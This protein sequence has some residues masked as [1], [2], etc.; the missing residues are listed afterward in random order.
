MILLI[1]SLPF[2][3]IIKAQTISKESFQ[4]VRPVAKLNYVP[5]TLNDFSKSSLG[6]TESDLITLPNGKKVTMKEYLKTVNYVE[7]N[8]SDLGYSKDRQ[9]N[10][11]VLSKFKSSAPDL[12]ELSTATKAPLTKT[13]LANR[14]TIASTP[15]LQPIL[16]S[17]IDQTKTI[18][19][20]N[21]D[22]LPNDTISRSEKFNIPKFKVAGYGVKIDADFT[23]NGIVDP[24][25]VL[26]RQKNQ[27]SLNKVITNT[28]NEYSMGFN[29][30]IAAELPQIGNYS[31]YEI[32]S[33][34]STKAN[35]SIKSKASLKVMDQLLIDENKTISSNN[36]SFV[37]NQVFNTQKKIGA[38][39]IFMYGLNFLSP[40]DFYLSSNAVGGDFDVTMTKTNVHGTIGPIITQSIFMESSVTELL[41]PGGEF[42]N[43]D[44]LDAGVG[45]ELRLVEGGLDFGGSIGLTAANGSLSLK[46]DVY[47]SIDVKLL[48]GRLYTYYSYPAFVCDAFGLLNPSCYVTKRVENNLFDTG[49]AIRYQKVL[50]DDNKDQ[51]VNW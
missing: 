27:D 39:D 5:Y 9:E 51:I 6:K 28:T 15:T 30:T 44:I 41:G 32:H 40:V 2:N 12:V 3:N 47:K 14:F 22:K 10:L 36:Y 46:N 23:M 34:F 18:L 13:T 49:T 1:T 20:S 50:F 38:A 7:K 19:L 35:A 26:D 25:Q 45:G 31:V 43:S 24:F 37:K 16:V 17:R 4:L 21:P 8:L 33:Q 48:R 42:I 11:I 29:V